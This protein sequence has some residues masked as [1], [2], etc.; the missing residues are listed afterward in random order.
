[1]ALAL[2]LSLNQIQLHAGM[3]S[4]E[5]VHGKLGRVLGV[6]VEGKGCTAGV[7]RSVSWGIF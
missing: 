2:S 7:V 4:T 5:Q 1:M 6:Q 3:C